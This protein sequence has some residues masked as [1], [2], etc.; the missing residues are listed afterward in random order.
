[1][2]SALKSGKPDG[3]LHAI[4]TLMCTMGADPPG[5]FDPVPRQPLK[6][7][8]F[9]HDL[10]PLLRCLEWA[11]LHTVSY[12]GVPKNAH[13]EPQ[14][15]PYCVGLDGKRLNR[16]DCARETGL[17]ASVVNRQF[18][19]LHR[20]GYVQ[21]RKDGSIWYRAKVEPRA[22]ASVRTSVSEC[23][24]LPRDRSDGER[25]REPVLKRLVTQRVIPASL[26]EAAQSFPA[27]DREAVE[28]HILEVACWEREEIA[29]QIARV[30]QEAEQRLE[31]ATWHSC[32]LK[33]EG[34]SWTCA[35][36]QEDLFTV[37]QEPSPAPGDETAC[38]P[39][40][41]FPKCSPSPEPQHCAQG[42]PETPEPGT[43]PVMVAEQIRRAFAG[44]GKGVPT[45]RQIAD[46]WGC[47][48]NQAT[49]EGFAAFIRTK[50]SAIRHAGAVVKLAEEYA[51]E[52][53]YS[54]LLAVLRCA[55]CRDQ[56]FVLPGGQFCDCAAGLRRQKADEW[57]IDAGT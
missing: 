20:L 38:E 39:E 52:I 50:L 18:A 2:P 27:A 55:R 53:R 10:P 26:A 45:D 13:G 31:A 14:W 5:Y 34:R 54:P 41:P 56:G 25:E 1:M 44:T 19:T 37:P 40:K 9:D 35:P 42:Q 16:R 32:R 6:S 30:R 51:H 43:S 29:R 21:V 15:S 4:Q 23:L 8:V 28:T 46:A 24:K 3:S 17:S 48:P 11:R 12:D 7:A 36:A 57:G 47:L 22:E 49:A 33:K